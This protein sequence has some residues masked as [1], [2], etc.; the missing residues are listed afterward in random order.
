MKLKNISCMNMCIPNLSFL[1]LQ[2]VEIMT[3]TLLLWE[4]VYPSNHKQK[5]LFKSTA[6]FVQN[7]GLLHLQTA[8]I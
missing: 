4:P 8:E 1:W 3:F 6:T 2:M 5:L 7:L